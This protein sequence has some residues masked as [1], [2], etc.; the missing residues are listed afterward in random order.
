MPA[1]E[2]R[3]LDANTLPEAMARMRQ[4]LDH[5]HFQP[6]VFR[7]TIEE[8]DLLLRIEFASAAEAHEFAHA[9]D[10]TIAGAQASSPLQNGGVRPLGG[11]GA[12]GA[13]RID[14]TLVANLEDEEQDFQKAG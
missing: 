8:G 6:A 11:S 9:F 5:R 1:V 2:I 14:T 13:D 12:P 3:M 4:W 7:S 10:G